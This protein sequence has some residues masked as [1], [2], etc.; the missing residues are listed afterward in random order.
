MSIHGGFERKK[1]PH[2]GA[3]EN[4]EH[5]KADPYI[6]KEPREYCDV[7]VAHAAAVSKDKFYWFNRGNWVEWGGPYDTIEA[8]KAACVAAYK[9]I[10][11]K[12]TGP[13]IS[14]MK[15]VTTGE[16]EIGF[17]WKDDDDTG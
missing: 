13:V 11:V 15:Q 8:A 16:V 5:C 1:C 10:N 12:Q 3:T 7:A 4:L 6:N 14:I 2:C 17:E 9:C